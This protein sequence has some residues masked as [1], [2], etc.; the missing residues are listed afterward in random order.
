M[1]SHNNAGDDDEPEPPLAGVPVASVIIPVFN[2]F[3]GIELCI[4]ALARQSQPMEE[5]QVL[6]IDNG[7]ETGATERCVKLA[8]MAAAL[9]WADVMHQ[10]KAGSYAARNLGLERANADL[11]AFT[12][13]DC[14]PDPD[15][16]RVGIAKL[17]DDS[18]VHAVAGAIKVFSQDANHRTGPELY[19]LRHGFQQQKYVEASGFGATA[20]LFAR[21]SAFDS[22][23]KFDSTLRSGGDKEWGHRV[24][25]KG[26]R[27]VWEPTAVV[28]HPARRT[29]E[30]LR[31]KAKRVVD[32]DVRLRQ[33]QGWRRINW[34]RYCLQPMRP[35]LRTIW[36]ARKDPALHSTSEWWRYGA[37]FI[38]IRYITAQYRLRR[39]AD[40]PK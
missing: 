16:L 17:S 5:V 38:T 3:A 33:R 25:A 2:D 18:T 40:W 28:R 27:M 9:P 36:R 12:D 13:A 26:L 20:N 35:P 7:P 14:L 31:S 21:R 37:T 23:G 24:K 22:V 6:I 19:E 34:L 8:A 4:G 11:L 30:D 39:L 29:L 1:S 15:W 32:G 10:P